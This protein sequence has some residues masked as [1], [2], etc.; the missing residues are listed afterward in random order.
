MVEIGMA[1]YGWDGSERQVAIGY[2][3]E[4]G[5]SKVAVCRPD[6]DQPRA[7]VTRLVKQGATW[8]YQL[9]HII[10]TNHNLRLVMVRS[11]LIARAT[12]GKPQRG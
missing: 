2:R 4:S 3:D 5:R 8:T 6:R 7:R 1:E 12:D 9:Q 11:T 10:N